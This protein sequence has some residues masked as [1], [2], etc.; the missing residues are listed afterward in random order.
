MLKTSNFQIESKDATI[1]TSVLS[2]HSRFAYSI[3]SDGYLYAFNLTTF[4]V[5]SFSKITN[6]IINQLA[7]HPTKNMLVYITEGGEL[8]FLQP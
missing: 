1:E 8:T 2:N 5:E 4:K 6:D 7:H 3:T